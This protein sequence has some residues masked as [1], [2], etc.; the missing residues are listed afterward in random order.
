M[1][2]SKPT[3]AKK[4]RLYPTKQDRHLL[5]Q[6]FGCSRKVWNVFLDKCWEQYSE[7][8][9]TPSHFDMCSMLTE[10][11]QEDGY[12][13]LN[14]AQASSLQHTLGN[15]ARAFQNLKAGRARQ[16]KYKSRFKRQSIGYPQG[17]KFEDGYV[18]LPKIGWIRFRGNTDGTEYNGKTVTVSFDRDGTYW[19][20]FNYHPIQQKM[21]AVTESNTLGLDM[22]VKDMITKST[23]MKVNADDVIQGFSIQ[24]QRLECKVKRYQRK[25]S[26][27]RKGS[28]RRKRTRL[29]L[30]RAYSKLRR[31]RNFLLHIMSHGW[32]RKYHLAIEDL[33]VKGMKGLR[34]I[35]AKLQKIGLGEFRR[36]LEYKAPLMGR[37]CIVID[38]WFPSSK[39]CGNCGNLNKE[40]T[41]ADRT[42]TCDCGTTHDR[43]VNAALNIKNEGLR[44]IRAEGMLALGYA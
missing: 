38:R 12:E 42:W 1:T 30:A 21:N 18:Y 27:Q 14:T 11:K 26:R 3:L 5:S 6:H 9:K 28:R 44:I 4:C 37:R 29:L 8:G 19:V 13:F 2:D 36:Q 20:S 31:H 34:S 41:L 35:A 15:L 43:D 39:M 17:C 24:D 7:T 40:L 10:S 25:M 33:N 16:P 22:G 32:Y 23:G